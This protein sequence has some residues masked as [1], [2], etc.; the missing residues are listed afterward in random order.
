MHKNAAGHNREEIVQQ[1]RDEDESVGDYSSY[2][3]IG[4]AVE[5]I[6]QWQLAGHQIGYL[7][8][9][10]K[11]EQIESIRQV[12]KKYDFPDGEIYY[13]EGD[14]SYADVAGRVMPDVLVEDDC[15]SVCGE[16][17]MTYP[18]IDPEKKKQ[19]KSIPVKEFGGIDEV[20]I[21]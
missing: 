6:R 7:T 15:E 3:P 2:V 8:S 10:R 19:I 14:E 5:K 9:R 18:Q 21:K 1:I 16:F 12:L 11:P 13:R 4:R 17:D 20:E